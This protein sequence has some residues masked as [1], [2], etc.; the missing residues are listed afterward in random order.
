MTVTLARGREG[1]ERVKVLA[2]SG[3][4]GVVVVVLSVV[5]VVVVVVSCGW[6][7]RRTRKRAEG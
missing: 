4:G 5:V 1:R 2:E 6:P 7:R 3:G